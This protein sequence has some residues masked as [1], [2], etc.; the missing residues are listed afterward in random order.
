MMAPQA[1][2]KISERIQALQQSSQYPAHKEGRQQAIDTRLSV[3]GR[4]ARFSQF[5][6]GKPLEPVR[7]KSIS[8]NNQRQIIGNRIPRA[9]MG[10]TSGDQ[11]A[12]DALAGAQ[13]SV[14]AG[15]GAT[16]EQKNQRRRSEDISMLNTSR[17]SIMSDQSS[18]SVP[19]PNMLRANSAIL[20]E[21]IDGV[22]K[23][24]SLNA[25]VDPSEWG[26]R[27]RT[28]LTMCS[29]GYVHSSVFVT[30]PNSE[31]VRGG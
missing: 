28:M 12:G 1:N 20:A 18:Q 8:D 6:T 24:E 13:R 22:G 4:A 11:G 2:N 23:G 27:L 26:V 31:A 15:A 30:L 17:L 25:P 3:K 29:L 9:S 7:Y 19:T 14:S 21:L 5:D 10:A 16:I